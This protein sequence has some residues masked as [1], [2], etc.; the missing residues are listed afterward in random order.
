MTVKHFITRGTELRCASYSHS[1]EGKRGVKNRSK[2][3]P[4]T[5]LLIEDRTSCAVFGPVLGLTKTLR[6][7]CSAVG[8]NGARVAKQQQQRLSVCIMH[9]GRQW[10]GGTSSAVTAS[11]LR[12]AHAAMIV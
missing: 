11:L 4:F 5:V 2:W 8:R 9:L 12:H 6:E 3:N 10:A 7:K 1:L